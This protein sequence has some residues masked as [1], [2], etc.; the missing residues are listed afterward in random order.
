MSSD[1]MT[2]ER[3]EQGYVIVLP[4]IEGR[5]ILNRSIVRGLVAAEVPYA[6]EIHDWTYGPLG[7]FCNLR[8]RRRHQTQAAVIAG[9]IVRY[10]QSHSEQPLYLIG[11]SGGGAMTLFTLE[12]L[13]EP[14]RA[15]GGIMLLA[16]ISPTYD[17]G[18]ALAK[19]QRGLWSFSSWADAFF[20]GL[21]T[22]VCGTCDGK[23]RLAAG[24]TGFASATIASARHSARQKYNGAPPQLH[25]IPFRPTMLRQA[26]LGGH[27]GPVNPL[28]V[29]RWIAPI[30]MGQEAAE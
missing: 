10:R 11:H 25:E 20:V 14:A 12:K 3:L 9:K 4:G 6:V 17:F 8:H 23:H 26:N 18:P 19:T 2:S 24:M 7:Y 22:L 5:S 1:L 16:A 13:P 29:R 30:V 27:F 15:T 21:G 28:F